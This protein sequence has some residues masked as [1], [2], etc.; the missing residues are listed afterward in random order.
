MTI[1]RE[2]IE[3]DVLIVGGGPA[4]HGL[5]LVQA[6]LEVGQLARVVAVEDLEAGQLVLDE[7]DQGLEGAFRQGHLSHSRI[8]PRL[9]V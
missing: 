5:E 9:S 4:G 7:I 6:L 8:P 3:F 2:S 1:E